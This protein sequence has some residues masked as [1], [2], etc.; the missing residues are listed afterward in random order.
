MGKY[1]SLA[2][3]AFGVVAVVMIWV[4]MVEA[5]GAPCP[6]GRF[7]M[8]GQDEGDP[9]HCTP[10]E[11]GTFTQFT[12]STSCTDCPAGFFQPSTEGMDCTPCNYGTAQSEMGQIACDACPAGT[13]QDQLGQE[14]CLPCE[15]GKFNA[16]EGEAF[17]DICEADTF[18]V[19]GQTVCEACETGTYAEAGSETCASL[20]GDGILFTDESCDDGNLSL[21]DGC[22]A[23][24]LYE[25]YSDLEDAN[26]GIDFASLRAGQ[27][28]FLSSPTPGESGLFL[29]PSLV[30]V[31]CDCVWSL[32]PESVGD[33]S[34]ATACSAVLNLTGAGQANLSLAQT[35][36]GDEAT[37]YNQTLIVGAASATPAGGGCSLVR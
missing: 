1:A 21:R 26:T 14:E 17:C 9:D 33:L 31:D 27:R 18:S 24:C 23:G 30:S 25:T 4:G 3:K 11:P 22:D 28:I 7:S 16:T 5:A 15:A 32:N 10:C 35:C 13:Y 34:N 6:V 12:G 36:P 2:V 37:T 19:S 20:C 29:L 8:T